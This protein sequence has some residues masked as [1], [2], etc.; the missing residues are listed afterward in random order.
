[1][2]SNRGLKNR[3]GRRSLCQQPPSL[4]R[5][6]SLRFAVVPITI[7]LLFS[8][9]QT[10]RVLAAPV[11]NKSSVCG[12]SPDGR[13]LEIHPTTIGGLE[14]NGNRFSAA[15]FKKF[16]ASLAHHWRPL[17]SGDLT[18]LP[19]SSSG[20]LLEFQIQNYDRRGRDC[21]LELQAPWLQEV[22]FWSLT[23][24]E[25][26]GQNQLARAGTLLP[27]KE[28]QVSHRSPAFLF[29]APPEKQTRVFVHVRNQ[30]SYMLP[31]LFHGERGF[32]AKLPR[33]YLLL[34]IFFGLISVL[35]LYHLILSLVVREKLFLYYALYLAGT[36]GVNLVLLGLGFHWLYPAWP[37]LHEIFLWV[38]PL[39]T[40]AAGF[41]F[42]REF[43][44]LDRDSRLVRGLVGGAIWF[45]VVM[46]G[47]SLFLTYHQNYQISNILLLIIS[48][49]V[50]LL[51][52][53]ALVRRQE[54]S[55]L[56]LAGWGALVV[57]T[58]LEVLTSMNLLA[59]G[60]VGRFG[61]QL[62]TLVEVVVFSLAIGRRMRWLR[63]RNREVESRMLTLEAEL[64]FA[65][66]I[67]QRNLPHRKPDKDL[68][69]IEEYFHPYY[70]LGGDLYD[71][72]I[73]P[74]RKGVGVF[75]GDVAGHGIA[76]ALNSS[77]V[78]A[79]FLAAEH[80]TDHPARILASMNFFLRSHLADHFVSAVYAFFDPRAAN[81]KISLAG[82]P[83]PLL[84]RQGRVQSL[85]P[86][87]ASVY[88]GVRENP[89]YGEVEVTVRS[90]DQVLLFT[91]GLYEIF[92]E[93]GAGVRDRLSHPA[94]FSGDTATAAP[95]QLDY[96]GFTRELARLADRHKGVGTELVVERMRHLRAGRE[97]GDDITL[98]T[99]TFP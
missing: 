48:P 73:L 50:L 38:S 39:L 14:T 64:K 35:F 68:L 18:I 79:A 95:R 78:K 41:T 6:R 32:F 59:G 87:R 99:L 96:E 80:Y 55:R 37:G 75:L 34:G 82:H 28:W 47:V 20:Y 77:I 90:G 60:Q 46:A 65:Q 3:P 44:N 5:G 13:Y 71:Y 16:L 89:D 7:L 12:Q 92:P 49:A 93:N 54:Q 94:G 56:F 25:E 72:A 76:A 74:D 45:F 9:P 42:I 91:D 81:L 63:E 2:I 33:E 4:K 22:V 53:R 83:P 43:L 88:L 21:V 36:L 70:G 84:V 1:M 97:I 8:L 62:G 67:H 11:E 40:Y 98:L 51:G 24:Q 17:P 86:G 66:K 85:D 23:G 57:G 27:K 69:S 29:Y 52:I 19:E 26:L 10:N 31:I 30:G 61:I 15:A 58:T